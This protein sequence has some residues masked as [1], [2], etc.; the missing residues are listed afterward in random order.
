MQKAQHPSGVPVFSDASVIHPYTRAQTIADVLL[1]DVTRTAAEAG[2][3]CPVALTRAGYVEC[4]AWDAG[5]PEIQDESGTTLEASS[6][7][8]P[9]LPG[10]VR[11]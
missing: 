5:N 11:L 4:V 1:V 9:L 3:S 8:P 10:P 7:W 6:G 2:F